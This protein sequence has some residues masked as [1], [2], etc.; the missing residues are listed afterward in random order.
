MI[1]ALPTNWSCINGV[2]GVQ[3]LAGPQKLAIPTGL[4][5]D[6]VVIR[7]IDG[8]AIFTTNGS[9]PSVGVGRAYDANTDY[10]VSAEDA[11]ALKVIEDDATGIYVEFYAV[12]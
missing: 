9:T 8:S 4:T 6:N 10:L 3:A 5:F 7:P 1:I 2:G 11:R 12:K